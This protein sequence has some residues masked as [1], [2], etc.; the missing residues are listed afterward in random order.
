MLWTFQITESFFEEIFKKI[1][2]EDNLLH[3]INIIFDF[4]AVT[5]NYK[6]VAI[7]SF[8][9]ENTLRNFNDEKIYLKK[10]VKHLFKKSILQNINYH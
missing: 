8:E 3:K 5:E 2:K 4:I 10:I 6:Y 1:Q 9:N 7:N